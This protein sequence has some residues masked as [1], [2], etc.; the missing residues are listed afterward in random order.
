MKLVAI[1]L[2]DYGIF[3]DQLLSFSSDYKVIRTVESE[4][5]ISFRLEHERKLPDH[6]FAVRPSIEECVSSVSAI[7]GKNGSGKTSIARLLCNLPVRGDHFRDAKIVVIVEVDKR[8][9]V[10]TSYAEGKIHIEVNNA[11]KVVINT[12]SNNDAGDLCR[13]PIKSFYSSPHFTPEQ[14]A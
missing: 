2:G 5:R 3:Q 13:I 6:F 14:Y 8:L 11:E 12:L 1:Y 10:Y 7:I 9:V 4:D